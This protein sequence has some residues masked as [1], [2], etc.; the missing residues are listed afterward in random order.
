MATNFCPPGH[1]CPAGTGSE[2]SKN[3]VIGLLNGKFQVSNITH[4]WEGWLDPS[5]KLEHVNVAGVP[6][7][8]RDQIKS[9]QQD[10]TK[11]IL[12]QFC[13]E[14]EP[15]T[16]PSRPCSCNDKFYCR[17]RTKTPRQDA[18]ARSFTD[19]VVNVCYSGFEC[20][21]GSS[22]PEG[23]GKC[24]KGFYC[25]TYNADN[26]TQLGRV[27]CDAGNSCPSE[28]QTSGVRCKPG[29]Y[30]D[31]PKREHCL[32]CPKG[33]ICPAVNADSDY[34]TGLVDQVKCP[35]GY[36]C[37]S[38]SL[39][40]P[41]TPC[42]AGHYCPQGRKTLTPCKS[43]ACE[44]MD[45]FTM[46]MLSKTGKCRGGL[47]HGADCMSDNDCKGQLPLCCDD[48]ATNI[49][50]ETTL[51][52]KGSI[53]DC[54]VKTCARPRSNTSTSKNHYP[55]VWDESDFSLRK[56]FEY[57]CCR[58]PFHSMKCYKPKCVVPKMCVNPKHAAS[59]PTRSFA[60]QCQDHRDCC[61]PGDAVENLIVSDGKAIY[62]KIE[63]EGTLATSDTQLDE[64]SIC[65]VLVEGQIF[66]PSAASVKAG[67][68]SLTEI[69]RMR[70]TLQANET[71]EENALIFQPATGATGYVMQSVES[72]CGARCEYEV[73]VTT[74]TR[75]F[76]PH[77][78]PVIV[79]TSKISN[80]VV[81]LTKSSRTGTA[82]KADRFLFYDEDVFHLFSE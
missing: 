34:V 9:I 80:K 72:T 64:S 78:W 19:G 44:P 17:M 79:N 48:G 29:S 23:Q 50:D 62:L 26:P 76:V 32:A 37:N 27:A 5:S 39:T 57:E 74:K 51:E 63:G 61:L 73:H 75:R 42:I 49:C 82:T 68:L 53:G 47:S 24:P 71:L 52:T 43:H 22:L 81:N 12:P 60:R 30:N 11:F 31:R 18:G 6:F 4:P 45:A 1:Y 65:Q 55:F 56:D 36:I 2:M 15:N 38:Q 25:P 8:I 70:F 33:S 16:F 69:R 20:E 40:F 41:R 54:C 46:R 59:T 7:R 35:P 13:N 21:R 3:K 77:K 58:Y 28:G 66:G 67:T 14:N 10:N